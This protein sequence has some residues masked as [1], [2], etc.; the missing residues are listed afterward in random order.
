MVVHTVRLSQVRVLLP[1]V[2]AH[3]VAYSTSCKLCNNH[4]RHSP[5]SLPE[6][7]AHR[8]FWNEFPGRK[9]QTKETFSLP[10][11]DGSHRDGLSRRDLNTSSEA[12]SVILAT[13]TSVEINSN[14]LNF[15]CYF[16]NYMGNYFNYDT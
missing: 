11:V 16:D 7:L 6:V 9:T 14:V 3:K 12:E 5:F 2:N 13:Q 4:S 15:S 8:A 10:D 1:V